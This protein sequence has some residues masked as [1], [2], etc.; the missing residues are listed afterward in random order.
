MQE[1]KMVKTMDE[2]MDREVERYTY[3]QFIPAFALVFI[4]S[5]YLHFLLSLSTHPAAIF[6]PVVTAT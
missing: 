3:V 6:Q 5:F 4:L 1:T 2:R